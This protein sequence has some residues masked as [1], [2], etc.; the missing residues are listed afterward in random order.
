MTFCLVAAEVCTFNTA[1]V[2]PLVLIKSAHQA[3][4]SPSFINTNFASAIID[5][6]CE[7]QL[8]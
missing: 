3:F 7:N 1:H 6:N 5:I 4:D 2:K 8:S